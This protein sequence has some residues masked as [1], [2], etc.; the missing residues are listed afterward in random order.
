MRSMDRYDR[1]VERLAGAA[2]RA[3]PEDAGPM[4]GWL[5]TRVLAELGERPEGGIWWESL[6][7]R[8]AAAA[9]ALAL[10]VVLLPGPTSNGADD[11]AGLTSALLAAELNP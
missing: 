7:A 9:C 1:M 5:A 2:R 8:L 6:A 4:P 10:V 11:V 3:R